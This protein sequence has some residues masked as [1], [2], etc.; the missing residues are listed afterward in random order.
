MSE[1][2][3]ERPDIRF[4]AIGDADSAD[5]TLP[6]GPAAAALG[7]EPVVLA[8]NIKGNNPDMAQ[9][10]QYGPWTPIGRGQL[11]G[12]AVHD[13]PRVAPAMRPSTCFN[14]AIWLKEQGISPGNSSR[15]GPTAPTS[16]R[17]VSR[18]HPRLRCFEVFDFGYFVS[19]G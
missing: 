3:I 6:R 10:G 12:G 17:G 7:S 5:M 2:N 14:S 9:I 18:T 8:F 16:G 11:T 15:C 1:R 4:D 19:P 13:T